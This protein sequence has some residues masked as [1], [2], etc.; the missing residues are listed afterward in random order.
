[1]PATHCLKGELTSIKL[2]AALPDQSAMILDFVKGSVVS[3]QWATKW[4][5]AEMHPACRR[6]VWKEQ[7]LI[8]HPMHLSAGAVSILAV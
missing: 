5:E 1:M 8:F 6:H 3:L 7:K 4:E 2:T